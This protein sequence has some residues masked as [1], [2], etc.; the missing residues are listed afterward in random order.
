MV[1]TFGAKVRE[2]EGTHLFPMEHPIEVGDAVLDMLVLLGYGGEER[3]R[4]VDWEERAEGLLEG[5]SSR[6]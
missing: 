2:M 1:R 5:G 6:Q 4:R 3:R